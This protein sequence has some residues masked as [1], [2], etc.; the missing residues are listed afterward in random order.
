[1]PHFWGT[2]R[3]KEPIIPLIEPGQECP[4]EVKCTLD[5]WDQAEV[6]IEWTE[7]PTRPEAAARGDSAAGDRPDASARGRRLAGLRP[8]PT[9]SAA[10]SGWAG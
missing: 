4:I 1:V 3:L 8:S 7:S 10:V 2:T 5:N 9:S 6:I